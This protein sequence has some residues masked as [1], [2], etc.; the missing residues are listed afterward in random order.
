MTTAVEFRLK[1]KAEAAAWEADDARRR[2]ENDE[3]D[4]YAEVMSRRR[5]GIKKSAADV[6]KNTFAFPKASV[7]TKVQSKFN[8]KRFF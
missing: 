4:R 5:T 1:K 6:V 3:D 7:D 8:I 2:R